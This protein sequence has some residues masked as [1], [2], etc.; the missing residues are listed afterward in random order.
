MYIDSGS[1]LC[2]IY[3]DMDPAKK[4]ASYDDLLALSEDV[5]AEILSGE[6]VSTPGPLPEHGWVQRTVGRFIGGPF[7]DDDDYGGPGGWWILPEVDIQFSEHD[8]V[9][10]DLSGWLRER[11]P[12]PWG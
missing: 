2:H 3:V 4:H 1:H 12:S 11:L 8:I 6:I 5:R 9:R 10:P 7:G